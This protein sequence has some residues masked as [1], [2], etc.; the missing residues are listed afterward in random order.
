[1][2]IILARRHCKTWAFISSLGSP[3][4]CVQR[5]LRNIH[6]KYRTCN[7]SLHVVRGVLSRVGLGFFIILHVSLWF[8][9]NVQSVNILSCRAHIYK[10]YENRKTYNSHR[11]KI[12][13]ASTFF[14]RTHLLR[15][16]NCEFSLMLIAARCKNFSRIVLTIKQMGSCV[17][18]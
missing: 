3:L 6:T 9:M 8:Y 10:R 5:E 17:V 2:I 12:I 4:Y 14:H 7:N 13:I 16:C 15:T 18:E 1:M 11:H